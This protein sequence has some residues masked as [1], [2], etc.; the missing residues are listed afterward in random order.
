MLSKETDRSGDIMYDFGFIG[1]GNMGS[2]LAKGVCRKVSPDRIAVSDKMNGKAQALAS[3]LLCHAQSVE[4]TAENC[5]FIFIGVKPQMLDS[6]MTEIKP[7]LEKRKDRFVLISMLAG[8]EIKTVESKVGF[9]CP[10]IRIMPNVACL[11]GEGMTLCAKNAE[12]TD[13]EYAFFTEA[14]E[15]TGK[16]DNIDEKLIDAASAVSGC[17]PAYAFM[18]I[19][20]LA[21]GAVDCSVP[22]DKAYLYAAKMLEGSAKLFLETGKSP[23]QLK[24]S[25]CSP[26]GTTIE[27]VRALEKYG[28]RASVFEAVRAAYEKNK[29]LS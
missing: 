26:G 8:T 9:P 24:D 20:A 3:E 18:M 12:V 7:V 1:T 16:T 21:D 11:I 25:V 4:E 28:F 10:V 5:R 2:A 13:E 14:M 6:L 19:E 23:S 15:M 22:R 27:G 29:A 17:G